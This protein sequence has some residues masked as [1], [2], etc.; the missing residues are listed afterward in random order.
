MQTR[1][2]CLEAQKWPDFSSPV[3]ARGKE[4]ENF[5]R[6]LFWQAHGGK[7]SQFWSLLDIYRD[8]H[9]GSEVDHSGSWTQV[10]NMYLLVGQFIDEF[11]KLD[12]MK[13]D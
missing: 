4:R 6:I 13:N 11:R 10:S 2:G 3:L 9:E 8:H 5:C 7:M 1:E 12:G